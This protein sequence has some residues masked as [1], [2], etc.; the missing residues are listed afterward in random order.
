MWSC[1]FTR[2]IVKKFWTELSAIFCSN[3]LSAG[4]WSTIPIANCLCS[5]ICLQI[6]DFWY[7]FGQSTHVKWNHI[8]MSMSKRPD[9]L[10]KMELPRIVAAL[11]AVFGCWDEPSNGGCVQR[12]VNLVVSVTL[13]TVTM[14]SIHSPIVP[15]VPNST[16][17]LKN[18]VGGAY[19]QPGCS[20]EKGHCAW[21][22]LSRW[23]LHWYQYVTLARTTTQSTYYQ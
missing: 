7:Y 18:T 6:L 17:H 9:R 3:I 12:P 5:S 13:S 11:F 19:I 10:L 23:V 1:F 20:L 8:R 16:I 22:N 15:F 2:C 4:D 14:I 21:E